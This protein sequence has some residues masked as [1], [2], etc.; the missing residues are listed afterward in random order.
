MHALSLTGNCFGFICD[1]SNYSKTGLLSSSSGTDGCI[2]FYFRFYL[3]P[4][5]KQRACTE[6]FLVVCKRNGNDLRRI[7]RLMGNFKF[8]SFCQRCFVIRHVSAS[9]LFFMILVYSRQLRYSQLLACNLKYWKIHSWLVWQY[10]MYWEIFVS[11]RWRET[12]VLVS[13][14]Q[15]QRTG[16]CVF[17]EDV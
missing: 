7:T 16:G 11:K 4:L 14:L 1:W 5:F 2:S 6:N 10:M 12:E 8:T 17:V 9:R 15:D 13:K 3:I